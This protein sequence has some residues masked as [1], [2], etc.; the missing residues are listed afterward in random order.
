VRFTRN[1]PSVEVSYPANSNTKVDARVNGS[2][3]ELEQSGNGI[4]IG[5]P[6]VTIT[7]PTLTSVSTEDGTQLSASGEVDTYQATAT[8]GS[9]LRLGDLKAETVTVSLTDGSQGT[10]YASESITGKVE[11]GAQLTVL[12]SP[13]SQNVTTD[14]AASVNIG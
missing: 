12:G 5:S 8:D 14:G 13:S 10:V 6:T 9:Q 1:E 3:L 4:N 7:T 2:T 11:D